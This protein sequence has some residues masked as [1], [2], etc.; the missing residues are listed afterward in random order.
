MES[1]ERICSAPDFRS[2]SQRKYKSG[3][4][5]YFCRRRSICLRISRRERTG[6]RNLLSEADLKITVQSREEEKFF[7][8]VCSESKYDILIDILSDICSISAIRRATVY[9]EKDKNKV[10]SRGAYKGDTQLE[11]AFW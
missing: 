7:L 1:H 8:P 3:N 11:K 4:S 2:E 9:D 5:Q 10:I 6:D